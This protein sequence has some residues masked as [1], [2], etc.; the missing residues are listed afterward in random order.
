MLR[1]FLFAVLLLIPLLSLAEECEVDGFKVKA[2]ASVLGNLWGSD[3]SL[4]EE[5]TKSLETAFRDLPKASCELSCLEPA[6]SKRLT[7]KIYP[8]KRKNSDYCKGLFDK[9]SA[10]PWRFTAEGVSDLKA[11]D[12]WINDVSRGKN[13]VG[14][15]VYDRCD[16]DCSPDYTL[17]ISGVS[18]NLAAEV[19]IRCGLP[20][21]KD[22]NYYWL[23]IRYVVGCSIS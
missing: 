5:I 14:E 9:T 7:M 23:E 10:K 11:L 4:Q 13:D 22:E 19:D 8:V 12:S 3:G 16:R 1:S 21:D 2:S 15:E 18:E 6:R 20:R 17:N